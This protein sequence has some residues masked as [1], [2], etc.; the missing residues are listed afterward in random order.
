MMKTKVAVYTGQYLDGTWFASSSD[1][2]WLAAE[3]DNLEA[4]TLEINHLAIA[5]AAKN[6]QSIELPLTWC[7]AL[8][9]V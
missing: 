7:R 9:A 1:I 5:L 2:P 6:G 8:E 3:S 4:L